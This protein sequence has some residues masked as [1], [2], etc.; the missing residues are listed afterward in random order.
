MK[1]K[2]NFKLLLFFGVLIAL[3]SC[4][5][6]LDFE[7]V[8]EVAITPVFELDF[9]YSNFDIEDFIPEGIPPDID[10]VI[11]PE[12]LQ[13]TVQYDLVGSDFAIENIERVELVFEISNVIQT[14]LRLQF[15]FLTDAD[16]PIGSLYFMDVVAGLGEGTEPTTSFSSPNPIVLDNATIIELSNAQ[17]IAVEIIT[18]TLNSDLRGVMDLKSKA[19]YYINYSL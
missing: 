12:R 1:R 2:Q 18:P 16:E 3:V 14:G 13:D 5:K 8:D 11:P 9:I 6:E 15:Q 19:T 10:F 17:K 7:Q 4:V